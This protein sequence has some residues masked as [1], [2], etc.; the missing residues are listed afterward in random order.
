M[1]F[2]QAFILTPSRV[3]SLASYSG[4]TG[5]GNNPVW[6]FTC[7][8]NDSYN[9]LITLSLDVL[10]IFWFVCVYKVN[11]CASIHV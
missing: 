8:F 11:I 10:R 3:T 4:G 9:P 7:V 6:N 2:H 1:P 5:M